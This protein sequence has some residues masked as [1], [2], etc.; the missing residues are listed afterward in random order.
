MNRNIEIKA[1][2]DNLASVRDR[3]KALV[4][5]TSVV[6]KQEDTFFVC[7]NG[8]LK[9]RQSAGSAE[10]ELIY[11]ER[12]DRRGPKESHYVI[13]R[14]R[15][16]ESLKQVLSQSLGVRGVVRKRRECTWTRSMDW[17]FLW[18]LRSCC[19]PIRVRQMEFLS[20]PISWGSLAYRAI[21][22]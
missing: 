4:G 11:Y 20:R 16:G 14:T 19:D 18:N 7:P 6:L 21:S 15:D 5:E 22:L 2:V 1:R 3:A 17:G 12:P 10:A 9:L 13:H 8:R